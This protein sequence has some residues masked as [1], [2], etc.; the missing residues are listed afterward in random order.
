M[1][2]NWL[3]VFIFA[4]LLVLPSKTTASGFAIY[5]HGIRA[6]GFAG[7][8]TGLADDASAIY[9]NPAGLSFLSPGKHMLF[10]STII[11]PK[12]TWNALDS[13]PWHEPRSVDT[14][15]K[16]FPPVNLHYTSTSE[17]GFAWGIG[18]YNPFGLGVFWPDEPK[19]DWPGRTTIVEINLETFFLSPTVSYKLSDKLS[20][21]AG[22]NLVHGIVGL[23][24]RNSTSIDGVEPLADL[25][26]SGNA[27]GFNLGAMF[28]PLEELSLGLNYRHSVDLDFEGDSEFT[29]TGDLE[30]FLVG[31]DISTSITLPR[32]VTMGLSYKLT[33]KFLINADYMMVGW[34]SF[35]TLI[36]DFAV[37]NSFQTDLR[38]P[39]R[40][41]DSW[42]IRI[43][44]EYIYSD[45]LSV[46]VG[47][48]YDINPVPDEY[49]EP[50]LPDS[51]RT[52]FAL[53]F[54][55]ML[56]E[57]MSLNLSYIHLL[58]KERETNLDLSNDEF[59]NFHGRYTAFA[60]LIGFGI[61]Y[62]L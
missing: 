8:F 59:V 53:G 7:A 6:N 1:H 61:G 17:S 19:E 46:Q 60:P 12:L 27:I 44:G 58:F 36:I 31:G 28:K 52:G 13:E 39:K 9:Y 51:D 47:F 18:L 25:S 14:K 62:D 26:G 42:N 22:I 33:D 15:F 34:S 50:L 29:E 20:L 56:N 37:N 35:D 3:A 10:G 2:K 38:S 54:D 41:E 43:G 48:L 40:Y 24:K 45:V 23:K 30:P 32:S 21:A 16:V 4:L 57:K 11:I 49:F 55:Y 5:E